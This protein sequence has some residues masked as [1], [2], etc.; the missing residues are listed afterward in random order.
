MRLSISDF[1][2]V[3]TIINIQNWMDTAPIVQCQRTGAGPCESPHRNQDEFLFTFSATIK[4]G[5]CVCGG[6]HTGKKSRRHH[7]FGTVFDRNC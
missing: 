1:D 4:S 3:L 6:N 5:Q 7:Q 2:N